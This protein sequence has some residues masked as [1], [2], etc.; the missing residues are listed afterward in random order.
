MVGGLYKVRIIE[1]DLEKRE[2]MRGF[3]GQHD[4]E[5]KEDR[6]EKNKSTSN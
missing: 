6:K 2:C 1:K 3:K 4:R 5:D